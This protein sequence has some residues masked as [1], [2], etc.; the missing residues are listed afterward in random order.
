V[1]DSCQE[2]EPSQE[3][4][5]PGCW[6]TTSSDR[7]GE[8]SHVSPPHTQPPQV[9][10]QAALPTSPSDRSQPTRPTW[11]QAARVQIQLLNLPTGCE[12]GQVPDPVISSWSSV[13]GSGENLM[14]KWVLDVYR[15]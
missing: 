4:H 9:T 11:S 1:T 10:A 13:D 8:P 14:S 2:E 6:C 12:L 7:L 15:A 5:R 3:V